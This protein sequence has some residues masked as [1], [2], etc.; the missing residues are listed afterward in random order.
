MNK[1]KRIANRFYAMYQSKYGEN[2]DQM[3]LHKLMYFA[4]RENL[5]V[6]NTPLFDEQFSGWKYGPVLKSVRKLYMNNEL[7]GKAKKL[8]EKEEY[9]L[10]VVFDKYAE[11]TSWSLSRLTHG[12]YSWLHSREGISEGENG[13]KP[14]LIEDIMVD[15]ERVK[16]RRIRRK[17]LGLD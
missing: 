6:N 7:N 9:I 3:K 12:E 5:I 11:K 2:I 1:E 17:F 10:Q 15:A 4:Q 8:E 16:K 14:I 13:N